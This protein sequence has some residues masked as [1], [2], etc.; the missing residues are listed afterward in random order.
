MQYMRRLVATELYGMNPAQAAEQLIR[1][2]I[3][4]AVRDGVLKGV[5]QRARTQ[6]SK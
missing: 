2:G 6:T 5:A 4:A 3:R 1:E